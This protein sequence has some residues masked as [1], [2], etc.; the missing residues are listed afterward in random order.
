MT[1]CPHQGEEC[2]SIEKHQ[3]ILTS[4]K[5]SLGS[6]SIFYVVKTT[7]HL[8]DIVAKQRGEY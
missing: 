5:D 1:D 4:K 7:V 8:I 3:E 2:S 6:T